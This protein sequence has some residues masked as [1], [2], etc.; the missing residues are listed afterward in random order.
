MVGEPAKRSK[1]PLVAVLVVLAGVVVALAVPMVIKHKR[2]AKTAEATANVE[3]IAK[4][5]FDFH[6]QAH[7]FPP[8]GG[9]WSP[10]TQPCSA[11]GGRFAPTGRIWHKSP[12]R[13]LSFV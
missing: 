13:D 3:Q 5:V 8:S 10:D 6:E 4:K 7:D 12:W 9:A 1:L 11:R 2:R